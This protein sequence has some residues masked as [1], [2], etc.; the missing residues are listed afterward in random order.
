[1]A[2]HVQHEVFYIPF[3]NIG[4]KYLK[5]QELLRII[6]TLLAKASKPCLSPALEETTQWAALQ[7]EA[8]VENL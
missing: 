7:P 8:V 1:M 5:I 6:H 2:E 4:F 3:L